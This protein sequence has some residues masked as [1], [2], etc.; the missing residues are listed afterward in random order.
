MSVVAEFTIQS[1]EFLLGRLVAE[2][3]NISVEI[4]R[5]VPTARRVMPYIWV[6][7]DDDAGFEEAMRETPSVRA[8]TRLDEIDDSVLYKV[9]WEDPG[10]ELIAGLAETRATILQARGDDE[11]WFRI[12]FPDQAGLGAFH[13]YCRDHGI[14]YRIERIFA[15]ADAPR[16]DDVSGVTEAQH[17][18]LLA[19]VERG[20]FEVPRGVTFADLAGDL[21]VSEQAVSER[22]RR[23]ADTVLRN[24][25]L[26]HPEGKP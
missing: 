11:W 7:G 19:A 22:V 8:V 2:F 18:A 25:L 23:G 20:Y 1:D 14:V 16:A 3:P 26:Q 10:E 21:G 24:A 4:E 15:G 13:A 17:E 6:Y 12:R 9:E 5:V